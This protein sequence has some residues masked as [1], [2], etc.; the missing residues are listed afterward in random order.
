MTSVFSVAGLAV[1]PLAAFP[2]WPASAAAGRL[3]ETR[4]YVTTYHG[5]VIGTRRVTLHDAEHEG[6]PAVR[7]STLE[8]T[9]ITARG[10]TTHTVI[11]REELTEPGG[12]AIRL[13]ERRS[14][15]GQVVDLHVEVTPGA[16]IFTTRVA[17]RRRSFRSSRTGPVLFDL[18]GESLAR[19]GELKAG[20]KV[21]ALVVARV[22]LGVAELQAEVL[23][24]T[25]L[26]EIP[27]IVTAGEPG[28]VVRVSNANGAGEPWEILCDS[29]GRTVELRMGPMVV[30]R[31]PRR[32]ARLPR[33][34][35]RL[36]NRIPTR[37][38]TALERVR[39]MKVAAS[40][41]DDAPPGC[42]PDSIYG[43]ASRDLEGAFVLSLSEARPDG[44]LP[45]TR[46]SEEVRDRFLA[47]S[48]MIESD[49][50]EIVALARRATETDGGPEPEGLKRAFLVTRWVYRGLAKRSLGPAT[51]SALEALRARAGDC[52]EHANLVT[53]LARAAGLPA[54]K[55]LGLV[56]DGTGFQFHAWAEIFV[57]DP[58]T[59]GGGPDETGLALK[60]DTSGLAGRW[61][62]VDP[63]LGRVGTPALYILLGR[64]G[65]MVAYHGRANALQG[66]TEMRL[67]EVD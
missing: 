24:R 44:R 59:A 26:E 52:T 15:S 49:A 66:R 18:D 19:R 54:R 57:E 11:E 63:T 17:G 62:P 35:V 37:P 65:D 55:A 1:A 7:I 9:R 22:E 60:Y 58:L 29:S 14:E 4:Y 27:G 48:P 40:V 61:V 25:R 30:R 8:Q 16:V 33:A 10:V 20:S 3:R 50:P 13:R 31:V 5:E 21:R 2:Q 6:R 32:Q 42:F 67:V 38:V 45:R 46:L 53:A 12:H 64:E 43:T 56:H 34:A 41:P 36:E 51:A 23:E 39:S 47:P 28:Y